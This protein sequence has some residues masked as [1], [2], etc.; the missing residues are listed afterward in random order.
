MVGPTI[1]VFFSTT[2]LL[3]RSIAVPTKTVTTVSLMNGVGG[4]M[5]S[6]TLGWELAVRE[7]STVT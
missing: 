4:A 1:A 2:V 6:P 7:A 5:M 3:Q